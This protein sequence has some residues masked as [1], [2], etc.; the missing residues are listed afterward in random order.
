MLDC[1][2]QE[3]SAEYYDIEFRCLQYALFMCCFFQL[4]GSFCFLAMSW[5]V[6]EDKRKADQA[7]MDNTAASIENEDEE[8]NNVIDDR[9]TVPIVGNVSNVNSNRMPDLVSADQH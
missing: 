9:D 4:A 1:I 5:Y 6:L 7:I 8:D 2:F 3:H